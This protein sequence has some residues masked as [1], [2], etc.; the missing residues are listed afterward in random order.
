H[1]SGPNIMLGY[2]LAKNPGQLVPPKSIYGDGW[3]DTGDIVDVDDEGFITIKGR[4]KRFGKIGGEMV[5]LTAVE[6][7]ATQARPDAHHAAI[8]LPDEKKGEQI[9]LLTTQRTATSHEL[10]AASEGVAKIALPRKILIVDKI[11]VLASGK[12]DYP[13]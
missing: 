9:I 6:Q 11:P 8:S 5:S 7:L 13:A 3:Y 10:E 12:T 4:S 1:V 2:L